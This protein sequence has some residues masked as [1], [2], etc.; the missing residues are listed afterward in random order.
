MKISKDLILLLKKVL[1]H[2]N[3]LLSIYTYVNKDYI[4]KI[5]ET[6]DSN[7][8]LVITSYNNQTNKDLKSNVFYLDTFICNNHSTANEIISCYRPI[9]SYYNKKYYYG[10][11]SYYFI[12]NLNMQKELSAD[13]L[14]SYYNLVKK[15]INSEEEYNKMFQK[16]KDNLVKSKMLDNKQFAK[17]YYKAINSI[18]LN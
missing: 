3:I 8:K 11:L 5:L 6:N 7:N 16:F 4:Y 12:E 17:E 9:I 15:Y 13:N 18:K 1:L 14:D 10:Q 2:D